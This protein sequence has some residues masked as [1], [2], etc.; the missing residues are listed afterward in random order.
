MRPSLG[1]FSGRQSSKTSPISDN[2]PQTAAAGLPTEVLNHK[3]RYPAVSEA[4]N[5]KLCAKQGHFPP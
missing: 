4:G 1:A 5:T 3:G 2:A